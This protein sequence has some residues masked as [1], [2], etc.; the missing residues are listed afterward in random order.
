MI[1]VCSLDYLNKEFYETDIVTADGRVL[2]A[3]GDRVSPDVILALYFKEVYVPDVSVKKIF[4]SEVAEE[5]PKQEQAQEESVQ[6]LNIEE[7]E[8]V[9]EEPL[10]QPFIEE[11]KE[12]EKSAMP[13]PPAPS[14]LEDEET[15]GI[16]VNVKGPVPPEFLDESKEKI[17][18]QEPEV[19]D[20]KK[21]DSG[22]VFNLPDVEEKK[23]VES[24][25]SVISIDL[26]EE[27][28]K[29]D[30]RK[31][32]PAQMKY[33]D[34]DLVVETKK[35][36]QADSG[37]AKINIEDPE[38]APL[39]F[40]EAKAK[41]SAEYAVKLAKMLNFSSDETKDIEE[42]A[43]YYDIG[44][45]KFTKADLKKKNF[46]KAKALESYNIL[47][48]EKMMPDRIADAI[49]FSANDY[50]SS[51]FQLTSKIPYSHIISVTGFYSGFLIQGHSKEEAL[52]KMLQMGGNKFNI[53]I[54]HKFIKMMREENE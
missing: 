32:V 42:A 4:Q 37:E 38:K 36:S 12:S 50:D 45:S 19:S 7:E 51:S 17:Q 23:E 40:D 24:K 21:R 33:G 15:D 54:L 31:P 27:P 18:E 5:E 35:V 47:I 29:D 34:E 48:N 25:P 39:V 16:E 49:K 30:S 20:S 1:K 14:L 8:E 10:K 44:I 26:S 41:K 2:A 43:Y 46:K 22:P 53:F 3:V 11:E 52:A 28:E 9:L 13:I 6:V